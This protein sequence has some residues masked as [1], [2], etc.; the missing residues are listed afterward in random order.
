MLFEVLNNQSNQGDIALAKSQDGIQW[1]YEQVVLDEPFH[2]SYPQIIYWNKNYYLIPETYERNTIRLYKAEDFP[3][4]WTFAGNLL[5][6]K[7]FVDSTIFRY[8]GMWWMFTTTTSSDTLYLY[9]AQNLKGDWQEHP[10]SPVI[11]G[12]ANIARPGGSVVQDGDRL[13][14]ITQD[15]EPRYG[16]QL[17]AFEIT[18]LSTT[19]Y[20]E[21]QVPNPILTASGKGWNEFGMHHMNVHKLEDGKWLGVV[22]GFGSYIKFGL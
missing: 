13:Y 3:Y 15:D 21:I 7:D 5:E 17:W 8:N 19:E 11:K 4:K 6:G 16:N 18:K 12:D 9:Y 2:L 14:R 22:D 10:L 20:E 1:Q